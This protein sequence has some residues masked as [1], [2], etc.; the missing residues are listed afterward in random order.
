MQSSLRFTGVG[1]ELEAVLAIMQNAYRGKT[2]FARLIK[3]RDKCHI[4]IY[5]QYTLHHPYADAVAC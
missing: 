5:I 3:L 4:S 2:H 1:C